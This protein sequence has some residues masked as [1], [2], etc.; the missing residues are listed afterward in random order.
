MNHQYYQPG[1]GLVEMKWGVLCG[2]K[3]FRK[4]RCYKFI[5]LEKECVGACK[6]KENYTS[7]TLAATTALPAL[8][9]YNPPFRPPSPSL[10]YGRRYQTVP[11][12]MQT[13]G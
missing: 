8:D 7:P 11:E 12:L 13:L 6:K 3:C 1:L 2:C 10:Y 9:N 5:F 4:V